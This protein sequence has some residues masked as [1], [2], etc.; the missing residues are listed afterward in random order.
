MASWIGRPL[1]RSHRTVVSR[2]LVMPI[3]AMSA[4][5]SPALRMA[6]RAVSRTVCQIASGSCSTHPGCG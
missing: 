6:A 5:S 4:A 2:W 1:S 3:A